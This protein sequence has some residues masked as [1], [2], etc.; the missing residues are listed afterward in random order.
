ME[1]AQGMGAC[2]DIHDMIHG[3]LFSI[4]E[5]RVFLLG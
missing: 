3:T 1:Y 4:D 2:Y 5:D